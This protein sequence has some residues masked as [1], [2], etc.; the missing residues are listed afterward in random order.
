MQIYEIDEEG[1]WLAGEVSLMV[2]SQQG[3]EEMAKR[4]INHAVNLTDFEPV[5]RHEL[6]D[7]TDDAQTALE[8][9]G[10]VVVWEDG[11]TVYEGKVL[12]EGERDLVVSLGGSSEA[13]H[14]DGCE[15]QVQ[16]LDT[17]AGA[18]RLTTVELG[19][20]VAVI[21]TVAASRKIEGTIT[22]DEWGLAHTT[23]PVIEHDEPRQ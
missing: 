12:S 15:V 16:D 14:Y 20:E 5:A 3:H 7:L 4:L 19:S 23:L 21:L 8:N 2:G 9:S 10:F 1:T 6:G 22:R 18:L 17:K 13:S 11:L